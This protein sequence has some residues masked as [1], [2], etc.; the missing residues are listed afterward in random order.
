M[1]GSYLQKYLTH[2]SKVFNKVRLTAYV[3]WSGVG[4]ETGNAEKSPAEGD[5]KSYP[6]ET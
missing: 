6:Q 5:A 1:S 4:V 3:S 2:F